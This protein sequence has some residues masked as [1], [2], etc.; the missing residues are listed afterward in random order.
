MTAGGLQLL[1][2]LLLLTDH[3]KETVLFGNVG[4]LESTPKGSPNNVGDLDVPLVLLV[5]VPTPGVS[6]PN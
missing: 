5:P 6:L 1:E 2:L 4:Q 3:L